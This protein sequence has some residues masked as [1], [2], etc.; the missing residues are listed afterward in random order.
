MHLRLFH[1]FVKEASNAHSPQRRRF[2]QKRAGRDYVP[3]G[4]EDLEP[5]FMGWWENKG[6]SCLRVL[7]S[8][9]L[10]RMI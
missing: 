4:F 6:P 8:G 1:F 2:R 10:K 7:L 9:F 5:L 3:N